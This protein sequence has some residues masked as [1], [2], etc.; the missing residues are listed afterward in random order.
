MTLARLLARAGVLA[1]ERLL[2]HL[3]DEDPRRK[4]YLGC[5][6]PPQVT[7]R[8]QG[9]PP[10]DDAWTPA[11]FQQWCDDAGGLTPDREAATWCY[12]FAALGGIDEHLGDFWD[13]CPRSYAEFS[14]PSLQAFADQAIEI[15]LDLKR[16]VPP[17][18]IFGDARPTARVKFLVRL[19]L[20]V[21]ED[22]KRRKDKPDAA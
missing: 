15:A 4:R 6:A 12:Q 2:C 22:L 10:V 1:D 18:W 20:D 13:A 3:C 8:L 14:P 11:R 17:E 5:L 16:D 21:I 7:Y 9:Q 19:I